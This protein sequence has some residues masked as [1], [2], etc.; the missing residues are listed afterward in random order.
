MNGGDVNKKQ[1]RAI[2]NCVKLRAGVDEAHR[3][4]YVGVYNAV[5]V[6]G[7]PARVVAERLGLTRSRVYQMIKIAREDHK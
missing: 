3:R 7:V 5:R 6:Q 1:E 4:V 2:E